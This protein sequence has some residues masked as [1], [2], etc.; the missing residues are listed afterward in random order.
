MRLFENRKINLSTQ[1]VSNE[2][3]CGAYPDSHRPVH[4]QKERV[5]IKVVHWG[6]ID[7]LEVVLL[8]FHTNP[9]SLHMYHTW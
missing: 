2:V 3:T 5:K 8:D 1:T 7:P 4:A 6:L 9:Y